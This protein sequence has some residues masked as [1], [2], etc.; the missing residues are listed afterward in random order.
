MEPVWKYVRDGCGH[1]YFTDKA[2]TNP[3]DQGCAAHRARPYLN[4]RHRVKSLPDISPFAQFY[5]RFNR[6]CNWSCLQF[7]FADQDPELEEELAKDL[8]WAQRRPTALC[9]NLGD[10]YKAPW[11]F[12]PED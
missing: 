10:E 8:A 1:L 2:D 9:N 12:F 7:C 3:I 11:S 6:V 4:M 5:Q